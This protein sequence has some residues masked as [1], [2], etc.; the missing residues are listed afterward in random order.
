MNFTWFVI[1]AVMMLCG[2]GLGVWLAQQ[3]EKIRVCKLL[4]RW[5]L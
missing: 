4:K 2:I 5:Y 1:G 3:R